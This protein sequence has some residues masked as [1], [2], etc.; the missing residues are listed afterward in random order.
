MPNP[1]Q[2]PESLQ[3]IVFRHGLE[4][5]RDPDF[6]RDMDRL[7]RVLKDMLDA[8]AETRT[9]GEEVAFPLPGRLRMVFCWIPPGTARI[10]RPGH[11]E[12][13]LVLCFT[14]GFWLGKF[15]VTQAEWRA[16]TGESPSYFQ[17]GR[18][19]AEKVKGLDTSR[20]PVEMV[21]WDDCQEFLKKLTALG[22]LE[23]TFGK[24]GKF[25]L[26]HSEAWLYAAHGGRTDG[27]QYYWGDEF[28]GKEANCNARDP[29]R[30]WEYD[31]WSGRPTA[32]GSYAPQ[33]PHPW[34]LCDMYGNVEEWCDD[35]PKSGS[36]HRVLYGSSWQCDSPNIRSRAE[37][38]YLA[39][40]FGFR[41][42]FTPT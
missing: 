27:R 41:V 16:V 3:A 23:K 40:Y 34:G 28:T 11:D 38:T 36:D 12:G 8:A 21:S 4:I 37:P 22:G 26:P 13:D 33:Y 2:L 35:E 29:L 18:G 19:G 25:C 10:P 24:A 20:F 5:H 14:R 17:A 1:S 6:H 7:I 31:P 30:S 32:V 15:P 9:P 39:P 42:C